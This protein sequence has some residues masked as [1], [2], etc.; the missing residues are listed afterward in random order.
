[1]NNDD[2][3]KTISLRGIRCTE[4]GKERDNPNRF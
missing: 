1:M 2:F 4:Y 3:E